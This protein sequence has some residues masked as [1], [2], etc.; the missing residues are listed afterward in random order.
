MGGGAFAK[1]K[2]KRGLELCLGSP[3]GLRGT[4]MKKKREKTSRRG[5]RRA[6][7]KG[8]NVGILKKFGENYQSPVLLAA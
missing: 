8:N 1:E 6:R 7:R 5:T 4:P 2:G 3:R